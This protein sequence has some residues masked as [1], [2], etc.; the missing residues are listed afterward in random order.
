MRAWDFCHGSYDKLH[1]KIHAT[2][3]SWWS[4]LITPAIQKLTQTGG[5]FFWISGQAFYPKWWDVGHLMTL[6]QKEVGIIS[7]DDNQSCLPHRRTRAHT[8]TPARTCAPALRQAKTLIL[9][10]QLY[11][12]AQ[13]KT[14]GQGMSVI[15]W[16]VLLNSP[17]CLQFK[18]KTTF[19][20]GPCV[21]PE[22]SR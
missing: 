10:R 1:A 2:K 7:E 4:K 8:H 17:M 15:P 13:T 6:S 3:R 16:E 11:C 21:S 12:I 19:F 22:A 9:K 14:K 20:C 5:S 18:G